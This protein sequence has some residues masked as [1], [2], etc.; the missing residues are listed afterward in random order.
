MLDQL[1]KRIIEVM[2]RKD[3][4]KS[5]FAKALDVSLPLIT[6]I[7]TGR[8][9]PG[10]DLIQ[11]I[12]SVF[13]DIN[14]DWLLLGAGTMY[15]TAHIAPDLTAEMQQCQA[16]IASSLKLKDAQTPVIQYHKILFDELK[17]L[18][19][20]RLVLEKAQDDAVAL[21]SEWERLKNQIESKVKE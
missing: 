18:E 15:R 19:E 6:H 20:M 9:K 8:N 12:I 14:P 10:I 16:L 11:K 3:H 2:V 4:T 17:H 21:A 7:T 1:N 13:E 5:S